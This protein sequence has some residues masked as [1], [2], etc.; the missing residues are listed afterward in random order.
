LAAHARAADKSEVAVSRR[1]THGF[2]CRCEDWARRPGASP[3]MRMTASWCDPQNRS[4]EYK[5]VARL[6]R[7]DGELPSDQVVP[8]FRRK[9]C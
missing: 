6:L 2:K 7:P 3:T 1:K 4:T 8:I 9:D 5:V